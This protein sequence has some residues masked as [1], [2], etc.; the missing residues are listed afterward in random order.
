MYPRF[1]GTFCHPHE[2]GSLPSATTEGEDDISIGLRTTTDKLGIRPRSRFE[3]GGSLALLSGWVPSFLN[4]RKIQRRLV[5]RYRHRNRLIVIVQHLDLVI[6][7]RD[8][9]GKRGLPHLEGQRISNPIPDPD[10][11]IPQYA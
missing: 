2:N 6:S 8:G 5:G 4:H 3:K 7:L 11:R 10:D 1:V 9:K